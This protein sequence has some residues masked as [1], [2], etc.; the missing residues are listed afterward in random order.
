MA[1]ATGNEELKDML[2]KLADDR[3][4]GRRDPSAGILG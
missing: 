4:T 1:D 3:A 2:E